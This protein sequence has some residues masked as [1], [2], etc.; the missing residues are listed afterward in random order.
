MPLSP[1]ES[2]RYTVAFNGLGDWKYKLTLTPGWDSDL[3]TA[4]R[5]LPD[6]IL[7]GVIIK[8]GYDTHAIGLP[9]TSTMELS[10]NLEKIQNQYLGTDL[11]FDELNRIIHEGG[12]GGT[13]SIDFGWVTKSVLIPN[14][15]V[16]QSNNGDGTTSYSK[17]EFIGMQEVKPEQEFELDGTNVNVKIT[18]LDV[19][20]S[21]FERISPDDIVNHIAYNAYNVTYNGWLYDLYYTGTD[22]A[23]IY[24]RIDSGAFSLATSA[25]ILRSIKETAD[26]YLKAFCRET[27]H[28]FDIT[29]TWLWPV[30][31][32]STKHTTAGLEY[33][34]GLSDAYYVINT[35]INSV[36]E[37][38]LFIEG[39]IDEEN[40][41]NYDNIWDMLKFISEGH[42]GKCWIDINSTNGTDH[43]INFKF[44]W[45]FQ[46]TEG[47]AK[48]LTA[49]DVIGNCKLRKAGEYIIKSISHIN[50]ADKE[51]GEIEYNI[52]GTQAEK[53]FEADMVVHNHA[54]GLEAE[55]SWS[56]GNTAWYEPGMQIVRGKRNP[57]AAYTPEGSKY[58]KVNDYCIVNVDGATSYTGEATYDDTPL[59]K[60]TINSEE[61]YIQWLNN[62][63]SLASQGYVVAK[64]AV[65][66]YGNAN[67][68]VLEFTT[69]LENALPRMIGDNY[70]IDLT[71]F[72]PTG[73]TPTIPY[74][75]PADYTDGN[76]QLI[77]VEA[78][79]IKHQSKVKMFVRA[80]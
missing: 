23:Y 45:L 65:S 57:R 62:R 21:I 1:P 53:T 15:W 42:F 52:E 3:S 64:A 71:D 30:T 29:N 59:Y 40:L 17:Y 35:Y 48:T 79:I 9:L 50:G 33:N 51:N 14:M 22:D 70:S 46:D 36:V 76:C 61:K 58:V 47:N 18:C 44:L 24:S 13:R 38:G 7:E 25:S 32:Y 77:E 68:A 19:V 80:D 4:D 26:L 20:R 5:S 16:L 39:S 67:Q 28:D 11:D 37:S 49:N 55:G 74:S 69:D 60:S 6:S 8:A 66:T 72:F 12:K 73:Y 10:L 78:D 75:V 2:R 63:T 31:Y 27:T 41:L 54:V 34:A 43:E 56:A